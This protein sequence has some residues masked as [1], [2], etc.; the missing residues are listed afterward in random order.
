MNR[1]HAALAIAF[2]VSLSGLASADGI[3]T[4][5]DVRAMLAAQGYSDITNVR[6]DGDAWAADAIAAGV[7]RTLKLRVD[8]GSGVVYPDEQN[9]ELSPTDIMQSIQAAGY[10]NIGSVRFF[11]GV[12]KATATSPT[13]QSVEIKVDPADGH[14][15]DENEQ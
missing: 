7:D 12:W 9:S 8:S 10:T 2:A 11:G 15:I 3:R 13:M 6:R 5:S 1:K 4:D 14:V